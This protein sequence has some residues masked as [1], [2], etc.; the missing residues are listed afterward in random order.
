MT[1]PD[2]VLID[3][4]EMRERC[5]NCKRPLILA[6]YLDTIT[7]KRNQYGVCKQCNYLIKLGTN[8]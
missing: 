6:T 1:E 2:G 4:K 7:K 3:E 5:G 8:K